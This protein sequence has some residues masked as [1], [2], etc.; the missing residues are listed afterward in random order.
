MQ[1]VLENGGVRQKGGKRVCRL[2]CLETVDI[3]WISVPKKQNN[4]LDCGKKGKT[5]L[6]RRDFLGP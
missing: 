3:R 5:I 4:K 2:V 1:V 6:L